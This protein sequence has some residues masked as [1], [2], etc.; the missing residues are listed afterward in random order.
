MKRGLECAAHVHSN[1]VP[2]EDHHVWPLGYHGPDV[3]SNKVRI[4]CNAH[5]DA[6]YILELLLKG[7]KIDWRDWGLGTKHIAIRGYEA[8]MAYGESLAKDIQA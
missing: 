8:V 3:A 7:K 4:C 6:H 1:K 2:Q 5:S